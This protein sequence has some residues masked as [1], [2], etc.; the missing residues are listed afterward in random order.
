MTTEQG[1][2]VC[3]E[4]RLAGYIECSALSQDGFKVK[5]RFFF[6]VFIFLSSL[7]L[8]SLQLQNLFDSIFQVG[9]SAAINNPLREKRSMS[10]GIVN[11]FNKV[12]HLIC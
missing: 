2:A 7:P 12:Q 6:F 4:L 1:R 5:G 10:F 3:N 8:Y 9:I 11:M